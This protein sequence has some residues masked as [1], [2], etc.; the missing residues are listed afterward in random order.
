M[1][2]K[3]NDNIEVTET[4]EGLVLFQMNYDRIH[5]LNI[6]ASVIFELCDGTRSVHE[7]AEEVASVF[8]L[9]DS[10][11]TMTLDCIERLERE[12]LVFYDTGQSEFS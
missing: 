3:R 12:G 8:E 7:I 4:D 5:N 6:S 1:K 10:P 11:L 9:S 2:P